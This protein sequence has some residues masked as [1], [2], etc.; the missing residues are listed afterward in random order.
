MVIISLELYWKKQY[1]RYLKKKISKL[2]HLVFNF[3]RLKDT[4]ICNSSEIS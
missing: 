4:G 1:N 3:N 2:K